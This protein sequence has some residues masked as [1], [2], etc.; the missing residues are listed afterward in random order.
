MS[1]ILLCMQA[2]QH[3]FHAIQN[4]ISGHICISIYYEIV[5]LSISNLYIP[6]NNTFDYV[7][8]SL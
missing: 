5:A 1:I 7:V 6:R 4:W 2:L 8:N 3:A